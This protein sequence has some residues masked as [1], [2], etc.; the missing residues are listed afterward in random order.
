MRGRPPENAW[1]GTTTLDP[2]VDFSSLA[3]GWGAWTEG[4]VKDPDDLAAALKRAV[5]QVEDGRVAVL[6]V[7]CKPR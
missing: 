1:I 3:K 2:E 7:R 5:K 6:D 4:P